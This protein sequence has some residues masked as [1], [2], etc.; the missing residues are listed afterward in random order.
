MRVYE[1]FEST[2]PEYLMALSV[3]RGTHG[4]DVADLQKVLVSFGYDV[5]PPGIDGIIGQYTAGAIQKAQADL[6][7]QATGSA[8]ESFI[9]LLNTALAD[10]PLLTSKLLKTTQEEFSKLSSQTASTHNFDDLDPL[11]DSPDMANAKS[12]AETYLGSKIN[13]LDWNM[14][15]RATNA[16]SAYNTDSY[17]LIMGSILNRARTGGGISTVLN[18]PKQFQAVTGTSKNGHKPS[19]KFKAQ[20]RD[21][22]MKAILFATINLLPKVSREQVNFSAADPKAYGPG[23]DIGWRDSIM[24]GGGK[25]IGGSVF[26][27]GFA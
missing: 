13:D 2:Q 10:Q 16:E 17:A 25:T 9:K 26:N 24:K 21:R 8:D 7:L 20:P 15:I 22:E 3:P 1:I 5:G 14:L 6:G 18:K 23:T 27:A 4:L 11:P 12:V 19:E